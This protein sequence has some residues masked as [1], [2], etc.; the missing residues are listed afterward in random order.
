MRALGSQGSAVI[1]GRGSQFILGPGEA[2]RVR[3]I[4]PLEQRVEGLVARRG[5]TEVQA[6]AEVARMD[7]DRVAFQQTSFGRDAT[8]PHH[9]DLVLNLGHMTLERAATVI[10]AA[11]HA[12]FRK[13]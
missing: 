2:L 10:E 8:D 9:Y 11:W 4:A 3:V 13:P 7:A 12:K 6:R 5:W 1:V